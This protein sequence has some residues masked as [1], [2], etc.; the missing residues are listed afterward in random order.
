MVCS[1]YN[2]LFAWITELNITGAAAPVFSYVEEED[3]Q[4]DRAERDK[5]LTDQGVKFTKKYYSRTYNLE[6]DDFDLSPSAPPATDTGTGGAP[7]FADAGGDT[8]DT[9]DIIADSLGS[10]S[11]GA[12]DAV[13]TPVK[14]LLKRSETLEEFRDSLL[15]LYGDMNPSDLGAVME[16]AM[17]IAELSGRYEVKHGS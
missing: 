9:A 17:M 12:A 16:R 4:K 5:T 13:I 10:D 8:S 1:T 7:E 2:Q 6:D 15:D 14:R 3:V 11:M